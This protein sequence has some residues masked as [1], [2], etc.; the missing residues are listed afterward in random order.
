[1]K[2]C[3]GCLLP[4]TSLFIE[5]FPKLCHLAIE[6]HSSVIEEDYNSSANEVIHH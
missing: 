6:W 3:S 4:P 5:D 2:I 1:M